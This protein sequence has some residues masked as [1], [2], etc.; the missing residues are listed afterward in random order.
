MSAD[1]Q[2]QIDLPRIHGDVL[3][4]D[5]LISNKATSKDSDDNRKRTHSDVD[6]DD[7]EEEPAAKILKIDR[8]YESFLPFVLRDKNKL[9]QLDKL[10]KSNETGKN[11]FH[12]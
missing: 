5:D 2:P 1:D 7:E 12:S 10:I 9:E 6:N 3:V 11:S 8:D 4:S